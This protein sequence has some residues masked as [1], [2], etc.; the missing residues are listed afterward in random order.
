MGHLETIT[1]I[2]SLIWIYL[3]VL[4][5]G[6]QQRKNTECTTWPLSNLCPGT[7][8]QPQKSAYRMTSAQGLTLT[9]NVQLILSSSWK[10]WHQQTKF[11][12]LVGNNLS[13]PHFWVEGQGGKEDSGI[14]KLGTHKKILFYLFSQVKSKGLP[15]CL[16]TNA[17]LPK[18]NTDSLPSLECTAGQYHLPIICSHLS[19]TEIAMHVSQRG[20]SVWQRVLATEKQCCTIYK[21]RRL[22]QDKIAMKHYHLN[23]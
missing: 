11:I 7:P 23:N 2:F 4:L 17:H 1:T 10:S 5:S 14:L 22:F 3:K 16:D 12:A 6:R 8:W 18:Q 21:T 15:N 9:Q 20:L 13:I 19:I